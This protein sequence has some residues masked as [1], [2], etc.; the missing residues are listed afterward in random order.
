MRCKIRVEFKKALQII[1]LVCRLKNML[2]L[3]FCGKKSR[4]SQNFE[5]SYFQLKLL[6][7]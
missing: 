2:K 3:M 5:K 4:I 7:E 1:W 6:I